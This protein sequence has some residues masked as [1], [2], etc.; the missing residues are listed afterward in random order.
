MQLAE[1][2]SGAAVC[3]QLLIGRPRLPPPNQQPD[4]AANMFG[5]SAVARADT[6]R[7]AAK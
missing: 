3:R 2:F 5:Q 6:W 1:C 7:I 4:Q